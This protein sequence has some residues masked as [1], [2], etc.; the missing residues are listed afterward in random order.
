MEIV[1]LSRI[2]EVL[3]VGA[4]PGGLVAAITLARHGID[5]V[6]IDQRSMPSGL[7]RSL[8]I[9][10]RGMEL[11]RRFGL[12]QLVRSGA[13]DVKIRAWVT[14]DLASG[15]G[16]ELPLGSPSDA[17]AALASPTRPAWVAQ[18]HHE[19]IMLE[20]LRSLPSAS[21]RLGCQLLR[22][23]QDD[24]GVRAAVADAATGAVE[25]ISASYLIAADGAHSTVREQLGIAMAGPDDLADYE[26][27]EFT[28]PLWQLAGEH[29]YGL[30]VITRPGAAGVLAP[31]GPGDRWSL[32]REIPVG[33]RGLAGL[34]QDDLLGLIQR[35]AGTSA[36]R[37]QIERL[38]TF[39]F[40]AQ[41]AERYAQGRCFLVGDAAHRATPRGGTGMNTAIQ[42]AFDLG[43]KLAWVLRGWAGPE[44]LATYERERRPV[45]A[46][47]VQRSSEP[48]GAR[49][50]TAEAL[51]WD[52][53][54]RLPHHWLPA[55]D[56]ERSTVDL[57]GDGLTLLAGPSDP[58][59]LRFA[60]YIKPNAPLNVHVI[61][62][63]TSEALGLQ[64]TGALLAR[65]DGRELGRW[66]SAD[67]AIAAAAES[68][69]LPVVLAAQTT[70]STNSS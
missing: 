42:D 15:K 67:T 51:P 56:Q 29:R 12:E 28:A 50:E 39:T 17:E 53:G 24:S 2:C 33:S 36:L 65:P 61:D 32:S 21:I 27:V 49:R 19:P 40:A 59:W 55:G 26:R 18:D 58:R 41:L 37:P 57:I 69:V 22:V 23:T 20:H 9:S 14:P 68:P 10:T 34:G 64:P 4:G 60:T 1:K 63:H 43:W 30:Y 47:N 48:T 3:V 54:G 8:V 62:A 35:A 44:V 31:R 5:V 11:M 38:S 6:L 45:A 46:H 70:V 66:T 13:A 52:L 7:S 25:G 16:T